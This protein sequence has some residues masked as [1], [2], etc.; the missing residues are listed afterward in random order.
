MSTP[1]TLSGYVIA[2]KSRHAYI[3]HSRHPP[4]DW[5]CTDVH[6]S[7]ARR[8]QRSR[9]PRT[10]PNVSKFEYVDRA[11]AMCVRDLAPTKRKYRD[12][13]FINNYK[14]KIE[15]LRHEC[16][17]CDERNFESDLGWRCL[18]FDSRL[19]LARKRVRRV[20]RHRRLNT[21]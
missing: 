6:N 11:H 1:A 3:S 4:P 21:N 15:T 7:I 16:I 19:Y 18:P 20:R 12:L 2:S 10:R 14:T 8:R 9:S 17:R 5:T 13:R